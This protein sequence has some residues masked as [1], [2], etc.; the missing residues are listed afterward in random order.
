MH[1]NNSDV[2]CA[3]TLYM[4]SVYVLCINT[5][6]RN[7]MENQSVGLGMIAGPNDHHLFLSPWLLSLPTLLWLFRPPPPPP[8]PQC[9]RV[10]APSP[11]APSS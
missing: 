10:F 4:Y 3:Y 11:A 9:G 6:L 8:R 1:Y 5:A 7:V 2:Y